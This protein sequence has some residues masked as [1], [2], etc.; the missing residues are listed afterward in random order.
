[1]FALIRRIA[2]DDTAVKLL[3]DHVRNIGI[4]AVVFGAAVWKY[5]NMGTG[6][7]YF[8][9]VLIIALL[10]V[11]GLFLFIVNQF[12]GI[13]TLRKADHPKW[14]LQLVIQTYSIVAVTIAF[15]VVGVRL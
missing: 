13:A 6:Y 9:D 11:L 7:V 14:V 15:A 5:N 4:C 2:N 10:V 3:F 12:H 8:L 1:M